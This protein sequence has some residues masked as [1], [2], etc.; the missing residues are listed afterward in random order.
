[1]T[2]LVLNKSELSA[3]ADSTASGFV[4]TFRGT[5]DTTIV[6]ELDEFLADVHTSIQEQRLT[7]VVVDFRELEFMNSSCF[8]SFITWLVTMRREPVQ[9]HYSIRFYSA[10]AHHWQKRSL[11]AFG[12][13]GGELVTIEEF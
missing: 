4:V 1:M 2:Q 6:K 7:E 11:H 3:S 12:H 5:A 8:K 10:R 9:N 13:F